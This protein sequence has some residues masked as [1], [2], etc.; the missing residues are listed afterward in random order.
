[1]FREI[2][3]MQ[4]FLNNQEFFSSSMHANPQPK[5]GRLPGRVRPSRPLEKH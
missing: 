1:M 5:S 3:F 2:R 4:D